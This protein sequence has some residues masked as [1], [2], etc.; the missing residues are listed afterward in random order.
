MGQPIVVI[1]K[2][3]AKP[4]TWR[5]EVNRVLTGMAHHRYVAGEEIVSNR[6]PDELA[7]RLFARGGVAAVH[8]YAN[9]VDVQLA[10]GG[11][12]DGL[13]EIIEGLH[14]YY[15]EGVQPAIP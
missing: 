7:R 11:G 3:T 4:G 8:I 15:R 12:N 1:E 5:Y 14:I 13:K 6:P 9:M 10:R 2:A